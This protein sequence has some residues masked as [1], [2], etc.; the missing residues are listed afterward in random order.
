[1]ANKESCASHFGQSI[2]REFGRGALRPSSRTPRSS[3]RETA[4]TAGSSQCPMIFSNELAS[5]RGDASRA[6]SR[7][8]LS[9]KYCRLA[10][11]Y[12]VRRRERDQR[13][14]FG[15]D[16]AQAGCGLATNQRDA[17]ASCTTWSCDARPMGCAVADRRRGVRDR[18]RM[19]IADTPGRFSANQDG[20]A[21]RPHQRR[22]VHR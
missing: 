9:N 12:I 20:C 8:P 2:S 5:H 13:V 21:G 10:L 4:P 6:A 1:V 15:H 3:V 19:L 17:F 18:A 7:C 11:N 14:R 22:A 16:V